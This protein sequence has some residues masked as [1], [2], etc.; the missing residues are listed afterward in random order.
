MQGKKI[1][2]LSQLK[3]VVEMKLVRI[4]VSELKGRGE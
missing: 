4:S 3:I 1:Q 2:S